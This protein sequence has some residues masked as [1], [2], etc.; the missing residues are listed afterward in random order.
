MFETHFLRLQLLRAS[1]CASWNF[2]QIQQTNTNNIFYRAK[3]RANHNI[4][5]QNYFKNAFSITSIG[6]YTVNLVS[7][8]K[9]WAE[10][11]HILDVYLA[12]NMFKKQKTIH[13]I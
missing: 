2:V 11:A 6:R 5:A 13:F 8:R 12:E 3:I 7:A 1:V 4:E 10:E 9:A